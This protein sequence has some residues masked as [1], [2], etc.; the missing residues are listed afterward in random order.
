[1]LDHALT[2][3]KPG[4]IVVFANCSLD[5]SEGEDVIAA[6]LARRADVVLED[7]RGVL[8]DALGFAVTPQGCV[9]T[10]PDSLD[11]GAPERSGM[12]GFFAARLRRTS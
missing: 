8:P 7:A 5:P 10:L 6:L 4:G 12:D 11:M 1:M 9:R 3:V 2:L